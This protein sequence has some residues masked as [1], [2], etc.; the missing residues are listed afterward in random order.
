M[1]DERELAQSHG[2]SSE[3][4][5]MIADL[6]PKTKNWLVCPASFDAVP[7]TAGPDG[8]RE[9]GPYQPP[10]LKALIDPITGS[11]GAAE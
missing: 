9:P 11:P 7:L 2:F 6:D 8:F 10:E 4:L 3:E 5:S 1:N